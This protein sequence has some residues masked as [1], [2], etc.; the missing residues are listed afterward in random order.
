MLICACGNRDLAIVTS[1]SDRNLGRQFWSC[2]RNERRCGWSGWFDE[3]MCHRSVEVIPR[4]IRSMNKLQESLQQATLQARMYKLIIL[5]S[6][7]LFSTHYLKHGR[8][9]L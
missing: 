9:R 8:S 6:W 5:F 1:W 7:A 4:L 2:L 3:P